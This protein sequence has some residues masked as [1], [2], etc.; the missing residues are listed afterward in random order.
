MKIVSIIINVLLSVVGLG[1]LGFFAWL[2]LKLFQ[3]FGIV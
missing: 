2:G 1:I 3:F